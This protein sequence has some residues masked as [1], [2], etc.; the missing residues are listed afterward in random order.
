MLRRG[1]SPAAALTHLLRV[2]HGRLDVAEAANPASSLRVVRMLLGG[3][4]G[5][6][7]LVGLTSLFTASAVGLRDHFRDVGVLRA[8]GLTP[9]QVV[10]AL[11]TSTG[12]LAVLATVTGAELGLALSTRLI[13]LGGQAYG[14]GAGIGSPPSPS[15][16]WPRSSPR[17]VRSGCRWRR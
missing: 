15:P 7:A 9:R 4:F 3:L 16:R 13:N 8:M 10:A 11:V 12:V 5:V 2:S 6:L 17:G 1:V 14:I